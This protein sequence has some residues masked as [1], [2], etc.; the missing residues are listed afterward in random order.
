MLVRCLLTTQDL[1]IQQLNARPLKS[2]VL[3]K[4]VNDDYYLCVKNSKYPN[5]AFFDLTMVKKFYHQFVADGKLGLELIKPKII[6]LIDS[7]DKSD[8]YT[9]YTLIK[10]IVDGKKVN[11]A[12]C[13]MPKTVSDKKVVVNRFDPTALEFVAVDRFD[14]RVLNMRHLTTLVLEN[15]ELPTI[16]VEV[17]SLPITYLS[18]SGS[19]LPT[20]QDT[21]WNWTSITVICD[22]LTTLKM[23]SIGITRLQFEILFLKN[24]QT[25]SATKNEL[26]I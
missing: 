2:C 21:F 14:N 18:I 15:C 11:I 8:V 17:G 6:L 13:Q 5:I 24:L 16:P 25:L 23:D 12:T 22:T 3:F 1:N 26:V 19:K 10:D 9:L 7:E 4:R 20:D